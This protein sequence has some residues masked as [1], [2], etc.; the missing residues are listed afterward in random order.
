MNKEQIEQLLNQT[1][2]LLINQKYDDLQEKLKLLINEYMTKEESR[3][4]M[5]AN[6]GAVDG[7]N[8]E[9]GNPTL[10]NAVQ[11][12]QGN[13]AGKVETVVPDAISRNDM[14]FELQQHLNAV[15]DKVQPEYESIAPTPFSKTPK[16]P[17]ML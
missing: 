15:K 4:V 3:K 1:A 10:S 17:G 6:V 7:A 12:V 9:M 8:K 11:V 14:R 13:I 16:P 5:L 2:D